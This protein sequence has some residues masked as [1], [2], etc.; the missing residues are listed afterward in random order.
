MVI[1]R[2]R[3]LFLVPAALAALVFASFAAR[4]GLAASRTIGASSVSSTIVINSAVGITFAPAPQSAAPALTADQAWSSYA[5]ANNA[6]TAMPTSLTV[7]IGLLSVPVGTDDGSADMSAL[8]KSNGM[9]YMVLNELVYGYSSPASPCPPSR[10]PRV[11]TA[12]G[13]CLDWTFLDAKTGKFVIET[14]QVVG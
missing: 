4:A 5:Q 14:W 6:T 3:A 8:P 11:T 2:R 7:Q 12:P 1:G 10:N 9:A 13:M